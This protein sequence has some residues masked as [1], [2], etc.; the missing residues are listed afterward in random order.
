MKKTRYF[1][2][3]SN[4]GVYGRYSGSKPKQAAYK[5]FTT[6][7]K[8]RRNGDNNTK[9]TFGI[10]E[11]T[12]GSKCKNYYYTGERKT[13]E[14]P[15]YVLMRIGKDKDGK[16]K[17]KIVRYKYYNEI[18]RKFGHIPDNLWEIDHNRHVHN[19]MEK[20]FLKAKG[21]KIYKGDYILT[22]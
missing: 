7:Y 15:L 13:F 16:W 10:K 2:I 21:I 14:W 6:L 20:D 17:R 4:D 5:I 8:K 12:R 18:K 19:Q 22:I 9:F 1:K 11:C 3:I